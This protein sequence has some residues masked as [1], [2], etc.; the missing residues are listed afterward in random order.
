MHPII[1]KIG[2]LYIYSYGLMVAIGFGLAILL[3]YRHAR[4]F[5]LDKNKIIDFGIVILFG[6]IIGAR[7]LYVLTNLR[8][9]MANP[10]EIINITRGGLV[11]YVAFIFGIL[12]SIWFVKRNK[13]N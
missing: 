2:P 9:Y 8:Y 12:V 5:G 13:I 3:A 1:T 11:W 7:A 6:G 10:L 4:E